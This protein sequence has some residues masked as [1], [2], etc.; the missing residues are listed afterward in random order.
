MKRPLHTSGHKNK[1]V[2]WISFV[3][4][5]KQNLFWYQSTLIETSLCIW[6]YYTHSTWLNNGSGWF[7]CLQKFLAPNDLLQHSPH[8]WTTC[9]DTLN[10]FGVYKLYYLRHLSVGAIWKLMSIPL[11]PQRLN[12]NS[13]HDLFFVLS[14]FFLIVVLIFLTYAYHICKGQITRITGWHVTIFVL[15]DSGTLQYPAK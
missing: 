12:D 10:L 6:C 4:F 15:K 9:C 1:S 14:V 13:G 5:A 8:V 7:C 2:F 11:D 3:V